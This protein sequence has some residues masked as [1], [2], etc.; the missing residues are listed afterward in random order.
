VSAAKD[1]TTAS[2]VWDA[3]LWQEERPSRDAFLALA[4]FRSIVGGLPE[5][6]LPLLFS[7]SVAS[8][9]QIT[10]ALGD[11]VRRA[12]ELVLQSMSDTHL[13][14]KIAG[15]GSPLPDDPKVVYEGA[16]SMLMRIVFL[17]F[18]EERGLL[19]THDL[20]RSAYGIAGLR[21][22]LQREAT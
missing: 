14:A 22:Q 21:E 6:R 7:E 15:E 1:V 16:V 9:E 17:L 19:P 20:Y 5:K 8:A 3:L 4:S 10:E 11:Q 2:G 12:V 13:R 18:A